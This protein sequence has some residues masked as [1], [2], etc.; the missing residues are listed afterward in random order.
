MRN[1]RSSIT[2]AAAA[3]M[4][5]AITLAGQAAS[6]ANNAPG[7]ATRPDGGPGHWSQV[8]NQVT[9][10]ADIGLVRGGD[11]IM[12]ILWA[13]G[14]AGSQKLMDTPV[15]A[16]GAVGPA[17][18]IVKGQSYVSFPDA[19]ATP[20]GLDVF[21]SG[22]RTSIGTEGIYESTR[23]ARG[24]HWSG[25]SVTPD[26]LESGSVTAA[27][28]G[29]GRPWISFA[30]TG[31][32]TL[33]H[34]GQHIDNVATKCCVYLP[35]IATDG[36]TGVSYVAYLSL[37]PGAMGTWLHQLSQTGLTG[38]AV[39][40]PGSVTGGLTESATQRVAI[41]GRGHGRSGVYVSYGTGY[42]SKT[43]VV[44]YRV[45]ASKPVTLATFNPLG[46]DV[47]A[48]DITA[49]PNGR[50][51]DVFFTGDG[52]PVHLFVRASNLTATAWSPTAKIALPRGTSV[53]WKVYENAQAGKVDLVALMTVNGRTA[54]YAT[55]VPFPTAK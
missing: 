28:A 55:Q 12:H 53:I 24:G 31:L 30:T 6:A 10:T 19:T 13:T 52:T 38:K 2:F 17:A 22:A 37:I 46:E 7:V 11:G 48:T 36:V 1:V 21:W 33:L 42:P 25:E 8:T 34:Q 29:N 43:A 39:R 49:G 51:W 15:A 14:N 45:G 26:N 20:G 41:T 16:D 3:G 44:V 35:G 40:L 54:Y 18:T 47:V 50:L 27:T 4:V 9:L 32:L 23:P 5:A